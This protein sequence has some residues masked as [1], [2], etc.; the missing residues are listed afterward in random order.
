MLT[1]EHI[2]KKY[3]DYA[4]LSDITLTFP[5]KGL[6]IVC[7]ES[8]CGKTTL[9]NIASG[10]DLPS[11]GKVFWCGCEINA[12]NVEQFRRGKVSDVYQDFMLVDEMSC[13]ENIRLA[14][15]ACGKSLSDQEVLTLLSRVGLKD[16]HFSKRVSLLSGG[17]KQRV[18]VARALV[19]DGAIIFADEPTGNLDRKNGETIMSLLREIA[20]ERLVV[21]VSHNE[22][23]NREYGQYF[24]VLE[25]GCV[26]SSDLPKLPSAADEQQKPFGANKPRLAPKSAFKLVRS[27]FEKNRLKCLFTAIA[28][29]FVFALTAVSYTLL[30]ADFPA[31]LAS[32]LDSACGKNVYFK[33][34]S[35]D[36]GDDESFLS[37]RDDAS[38]VWDFGLDA[39]DLGFFS[40]LLPLYQSSLDTN[41]SR[42]IEYDPSTGADVDVAYGDF[43]SRPDQVMLPVYFAD[44]LLR[45]EYYK[46]FSSA[47]ELV[48]EML[49]LSE[50][51]LYVSSLL[52]PSLTFKE[53]ASYIEFE[54]S[55]FF[56]PKLPSEELAELRDAP[57]NSADYNTYCTVIQSSFLYDSVFVGKGYGD[58][59]RLYRADGLYSAMDQSG[60]IL[61]GV[62]GYDEYA[63]YAADLSAP[64]DGEALIGD[65]MAERLG[66]AVGD[67]FSL[68]YGTLYYE[69]GTDS[70]RVPKIREKG[71]LEL[72]VT[73]IVSEGSYGLRDGVV[74]SPEQ[75]RDNIVLSDCEMIGFFFDLSDMSDSRSALLQLER[76]ISSVY[77]P[78]ELDSSSSG[79]VLSRVVAENSSGLAGF[80]DSLCEKRFSLYLPLALVLSLCLVTLGVAS[81]SFLISSKDRLYG[82]LRAIGFDRR[83]LFALMFASLVVLVICVVVLGL[84][85]AA[86]GLFI[87]NNSASLPLINTV[88]LPLGWHAGLIAAVLT[89]LSAVISSWLKVSNSFSRTIAFNKTH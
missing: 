78:L 10:A 7:G 44:I 48:G 4:A 20:D 54:I 35:S 19:K 18:S 50:D 56:S 62:S 5:D 73:G 70:V 38:P 57:E 12:S 87:F 28:F 26:I 82:V 65:V 51:D 45:S 16:E 27:G 76:D 8:G 68:G 36:I 13:A 63:S 69:V 25:D 89:V 52:G 30:I 88:Y 77:S 42:A 74:L 80:Y 72:T 43:P 49:P 32:S 60:S 84:C 37:L 86:I 14:A 71:R 75:R 33:L 61:S 66:L 59:I 41:L 55:G 79:D 17:E 21:V 9:L 40:M 1:L 29:L 11:F 22:R 39:H 6:V 31:A 23:L 46:N 58:R 34:A 3:D 24:V 64:K 15:E 85:V 47:E 67:S 53:D 83:S 2:T 81:F